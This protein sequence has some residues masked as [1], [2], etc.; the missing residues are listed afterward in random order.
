MRKLLSIFC[1]KHPPKTEDV[2]V[3][4]PPEK[5]WAKTIETKDKI[6]KLDENATKLFVDID[7]KYIEDGKIKQSYFGYSEPIDVV[8]S[9]LKQYHKDEVISRFKEFKKTAENAIFLKPDCEN[10]RY[11]SQ[12]ERNLEELND[13]PDN[14][15]LYCAKEI[16]FVLKK[17]KSGGDLR[18][19]RY[20]DRKKWL[21]SVEITDDWFAEKLKKSFSPLQ[22]IYHL[23]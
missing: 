23:V 17:S 9:Y 10:E 6:F 21:P 13:L 19:V 3:P 2:V 12:C 7:E 1:K 11:I 14:V 16:D 5:I 4:P 22:K 18:A 15:V 20:L 8:L